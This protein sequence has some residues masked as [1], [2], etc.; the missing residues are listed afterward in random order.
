MEVIRNRL[1]PFEHRPLPNY[2]IRVVH[3]LPSILS[4]A[5]I[6]CRIAVHH[7]RRERPKYEALSYAWGD[8]QDGER[9]IFV[10]GRPFVVRLNLW[11]FLKQLR[12]HRSVRV[13]WADAL[14][15]DQTNIQERNH[16]VK[17]MGDIYRHAERTLIWLGPSDQHTDQLFKA[18]PMIDQ[19]LRPHW[20]F[21]EEVSF[22]YEFSTEQ[23]IQEDPIF[24]GI[25]RVARRCN[26]S[27]LRARGT[28]SEWEQGNLPPEEQTVLEDWYRKALETFLNNS[29]RRK[30]KQTHL[31]ATSTRSVRTD[32]QFSVDTEGLARLYAEIQVLPPEVLILDRIP[33]QL[34]E[35]LN[36][37]F[38]RYPFLL[39][40]LSDISE[41]PYWK[42]LWI[43][44][45]IVLSR[46]V[47][48]FCGSKVVS[49]NALAVLLRSCESPTHGNGQ[50]IVAN[51]AWSI[52]LEWRKR[53]DMMTLESTENSVGF[54][55]LELIL[56]AFENSLCVDVR[57]K[58]YGL[59]GL[60]ES[61]ALEPDYS[62]TSIELFSGLMLLFS[63]EIHEE[64]PEDCAISNL[65]RVGRLLQRTLRL[66]TEIPERGARPDGFGSILT[67]SGLITGKVSA[68]APSVLS[69]EVDPSAVIDTWIH[70]LVVGP[71]TRSN[72]LRRVQELQRVLDGHSNK[73]LGC[74]DYSQF[75]MDSSESGETNRTLSVK[76]SPSEERGTP[77]KQKSLSESTDILY[78]FAHSQGSVGVSDV[79][80]EEGDIICNCSGINPTYALIL[81]ESSSGL[82]VV[83]RAIISPTRLKSGEFYPKEIHDQKMED[84]QRLEI[85]FDPV[86]LLALVLLPF[87]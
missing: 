7:D 33:K 37:F 13:V 46:H 6:R 79:H 83:G 68:M 61:A 66:N 69:N 9:T 31:V 5:P 15:I 24:K 52:Y 49:W 45:E 28:L 54:R 1:P 67:V 71:P 43:V 12:K 22:R 36:L 50:P 17:L 18:I 38:V 32:Y 51:N 57:D 25:R 30:R 4:A 58:I 55:K 16:Q 75:S 44:Q 85:T 19:L 53:H 41:R 48:I 10:D 84:G 60:F 82:Q 21:Y 76:Y 14:C 74:V 40:A 20:D 78:W 64:L 39:E 8:A 56:D 42:R 63:F 62:K 34:K 77:I 70:S 27:D 87:P 72:L 47:E 3:I 26:L 86:S 73:S 81:R 59:L 65:L 23:P 35:N 2:H 29:K 11:L 80:F